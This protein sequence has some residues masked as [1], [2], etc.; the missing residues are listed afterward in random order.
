MTVTPMCIAIQN[1]SSTKLSVKSGCVQIPDATVV[2]VTRLSPLN[3][4]SL[5]ADKNIGTRPFE[6]ASSKVN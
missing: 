5:A 2:M 4:G 6:N 1:V 3:L